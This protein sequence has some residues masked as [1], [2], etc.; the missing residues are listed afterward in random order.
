M[1]KEKER[2]LT[3]EEIKK[4]ED[5]VFLLANVKNLQEFDAKIREIE[6]NNGKPIAIVCREVTFYGLKLIVGPNVKNFTVLIRKEGNCE[7]FSCLSSSAQEPFID[8]NNKEI[9]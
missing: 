1:E 5:F 9:N 7:C 6:K 3:N 8:F 4:L 2:I